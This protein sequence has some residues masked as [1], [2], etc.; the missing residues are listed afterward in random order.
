MAFGNTAEL[1]VAATT[2]DDWLNEG[3]QGIDL[4][5]RHNPVVAILMDN[6]DQPGGDYQFQQGDMSG[7]D[8]KVSVW[9]K[10]NATVAGVTR[11]NQVVLETP[12]VPT[13]LATNAAWTWAHYKGMAYDN[14]EDRAKNSGKSQMVDL[15]NMILN[16]IVATFFDQVGTDLLDNAA[17]TIS[18]IQ[19]FNAALLNTGTVAGIDQT[20]STNN[21]W[22]RA[23]GDSTAEIINSQTIDK[24]VMDA[25]FDTG[26]SSPIAKSY[27]DIGITT[28]AN[29]SKLMQELKPSQRT[30][31]DVMLRGG[32][33]YMTY[34]GMRIF[35]SERI[36]ANTMLL[37]NSTVWTFRYLTKMPDP[38]TPGFVPTSG[39]P[40][41]YERGY[42]WIVGLGSYSVK[43]N[44]LLQNKTSG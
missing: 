41:M 42:N 33:K 19:S 44:G 32:A 2:V 6:S 13:N 38:K 36:V 21:S 31:T 7:N 34:G 39:A 26:L 20:D 35:N 28:N 11:A 27:P 4:F 16:Q 29:A 14:Y 22:W 25:T 3:K 18:K 8:F 24:V 43:H 5:S 1:D 12:T 10:G 37:L 23:A 9:G 17:G 40:A 30:D 15:G